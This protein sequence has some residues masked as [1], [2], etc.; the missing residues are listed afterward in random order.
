MVVGAQDAELGEGVGVGGQPGGAG[1]FEPGVQ[2]VLVAAFDETAADGQFPGDGPGVVQRVAPVIEVAPGRAHGGGFLGDGVG[3]ELRGQLGEHRCER[4]ALE[5]VLLGV[6]PLARRAR[7][8]DLPGGGEVFADVV[9]VRQHGGLRAEDFAALEGDPFRAV[10]HDVDAAAQPP[11]RLA[12][13]V[14]PAPPGLPKVA[15]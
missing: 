6:Q 13:G 8:A 7:P 2:D 4:S 14:A 10:G 9:K 11:A 1:T 15:A 12:R 5:P 3:F